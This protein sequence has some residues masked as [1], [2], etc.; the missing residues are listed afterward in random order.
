MTVLTPAIGRGSL[1]AAPVVV[2]GVDG[3]GAEEFKVTYHICSDEF[4][5]ATRSIAE[6]AARWDRRLRRTRQ[7]APRAVARSICAMSRLS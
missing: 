1:V 5:R 3:V 6:V 2:V 4:D 7:P